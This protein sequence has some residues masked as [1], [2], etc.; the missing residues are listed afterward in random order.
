MENL[1]PQ[2]PSLLKTGLNE[3]IP[4]SAGWALAVIIAVL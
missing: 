1:S 2:N 4:F 3:I